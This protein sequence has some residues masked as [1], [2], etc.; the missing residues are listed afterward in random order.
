VPLATKVALGAYQHH[1]YA[2]TMTRCSVIVALS[3][4]AIARSWGESTTMEL[5]R[6]MATY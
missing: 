1:G 4:A 5:K 2:E 6:R 3:P